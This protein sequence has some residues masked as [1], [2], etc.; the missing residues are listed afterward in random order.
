MENLWSETKSHCRLLGIPWNECRDTA[1]LSCVPRSFCLWDVP[2][3]KVLPECRSS[4]GLLNIAYVH[5]AGREHE[6]S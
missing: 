1:D 3:A 4:P 5:M 6:I 2:D